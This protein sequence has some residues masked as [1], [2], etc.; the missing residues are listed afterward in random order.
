MKY[1]LN[2]PQ[3]EIGSDPAVISHFARSAEAMGYD[4]LLAYDHV[5]GVN[6][7]TYP[8][9]RDLM[10]NLKNAFHEPLVLFAY[11]AAQTTTIEF[12][13]GV[14]V[15]SQRN[16][17]MVAKQLA[18]LSLLSGGRIRAGVGVGWNRAEISALGYDPAVRGRRMDEQLALMRQLWTQE[19]VVFEGEFHQVADLGMNP[20]PAQPVP[21]WLGGGSEAVLR[22]MAQYGDGWIL[23]RT[24][25]SP[26]DLARVRSCVEEAGRD[27]DAFGFDVQADIARLPR[28][29]WQDFVGTWR[30][31]G[32]THVRASTMHA[33]L[34]SIDDHL[35]LAES[36][37]QMARA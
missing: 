2:F 5:L 3:T 12:V 28:D 8:A 31:H 16:T 4:Y 36:F 32:A 24:P 10:Y 29:A 33:G 7:E 20:R 34:A 11:L 25:E 21:V 22:R 1:G 23:S 15:L 27:P 9:Q 6:P 26:D 14:L 18:Q 37:M 19:S 30:D 35:A 13:T 17:V